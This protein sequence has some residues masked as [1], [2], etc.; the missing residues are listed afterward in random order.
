MI[1]FKQY[2]TEIFDTVLP[3]TKEKRTSSLGTHQYNY[4]IN[5]DNDTLRLTIYHF[6]TVNKIDI[7]LASFAT[8]YN[9]SKKGNA[10]KVYSTIVH[11]LKQFLKDNT[12]IKDITFSAFSDNQIPLYK[13]FADM[14]EKAGYK[15]VNL[16]DNEKY[17][18]FTKE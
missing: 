17:F 10:F 12:D 14:I 15:K 16:H 5:S 18:D 13:K 9:T 8:M 2:I 1:K 11:I 6:P 3:Y 7:E 4:M